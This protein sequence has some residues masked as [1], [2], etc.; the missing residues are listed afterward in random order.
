MK[1]FLLIKKSMLI[2]F[3]VSAILLSWYL[4]FFLRFNFDIP[5]ESLSFLKKY[6]LII[7]FIQIVTLLF[8]GALNRSFKFFGLQ[9][10]LKIIYSAILS[11]LF[12]TSLFFAIK[13]QY[14]IPR[15]VLILYPILLTFVLGG[16]F[17]LS[18]LFF[19][20]KSNRF[21][22]NDSKPVII[23]GEDRL[24]VSLAKELYQQKT[25]KVIAIFT[26]SKSLHGD[27]VAGAKVFGNLSKIF[28]IV[29]LYNIK[30]I[31]IA[32]PN[33][34]RDKRREIL[35]IAA[36]LNLHT[37]TVPSIE[38]LMNGLALANVRNIELEDLLGRE[39]VNLDT[40]GLVK[41]VEKK[42]VLI[43][44][45]GGSIGS[46]I[47][48]QI[49]K[50]NPKTLICLDI[51]EFGLYS[52][53]EKLSV[54]NL[55]I[56]I[57]YIVGDIKNSVRLDKLFKKYKP[58]IVFH[59]AA[60]KHVPLMEANNVSEAIMNNVIGTY[61]LAQA[62][63]KANVSKFILISTD[64]AVNSTN[65]MGATKR[66]AEIICHSL[67]ELKGTKFIVVRFGNVLG[68][69]G[70]VIP[71]FRDQINAGGPL[72]VTHPDI[73]RFFMTIP[74]AAQLVLQS[75]LIGLGGETFI[76]NMGEPIRILDLARDMIKLSGFDEKK[77]KIEFSGLRPGEKLYEE[78]IFDSEKIKPT[79]HIMINRA[80]SPA[81]YRL[82]KVRLNS[83]LKWAAS[84]HK[85]GELLVK[86]ELM[87]WAYLKK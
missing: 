74:E 23:V 39:P 16:F 19:E 52:L 70:S 34:S 79:N 33:S 56:R 77:I 10:L 55:S 8:F 37:M 73:V 38:D 36:Q 21:Y 12:L 6:S 76:L 47:C 83:L 60:Y 46:E 71:K 62:S 68:S 87:S 45:A 43:S 82:G 44:G 63:K 25:W 15:S 14:Q 24:C 32:L 30:D 69:S 80:F 51:S 2:L 13:V 49:I 11:I 22:K 27:L 35:H 4:A 18:R 42:V 29:K 66:L 85:K 59:A 1:N 20:F 57:F 78:L 72:T 28:E 58:T 9:D 3:D 53:E 61:S 54:K 7:L 67:N 17:S 65:V 50:F 31:I 64:K 48:N 40:E 5:P 84:S 41:F 86:K 26:E 81:T 75:G